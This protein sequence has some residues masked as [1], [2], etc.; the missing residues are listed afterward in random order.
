VGPAHSCRRSGV[1]REYRVT[2]LWRHH[3]WQIEEQYKRAKCRVEIENFSGR[4]A[5]SVLQDFYA[6]IFTMNLTAI[7]VW[8]AQAIAHRLYAARRPSYRV[9]FANALSKMK[10]AVAR[11]LLR[12]RGQ[13][14]VT[15]LVLAMAASVEAVRPDR[16]AP[17]N[18]KPAK[19]QGFHSNYKRCR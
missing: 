11:L 9:N 3:G 4:S 1:N 16:S 6:K 12:L 13:E 7:L 2:R 8:V 5:L 18:M 19:A 15:T 14:L 17:R 10:H